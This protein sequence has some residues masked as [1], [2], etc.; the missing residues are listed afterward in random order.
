MK[1][2]DWVPVPSTLNAMEIILLPDTGYR[3]ELLAL[4]HEMTQDRPLLPW[5]T[6]LLQ[7]TGEALTSGTPTFTIPRSVVDR[8]VA[9]PTL[10]SAEVVEDV[11][12]FL[13]EREKLFDE[14]HEYARR[15]LRK[16]F[17]RRGALKGWK[18]PRDF[19]EGFWMTSENLEPLVVQAWEHLKLQRQIGLD[20]LL[21][22]QV[23]RLFFEMQGIAAYDRVISGQQPK[24]AHYTDIL[25]LMY[26]GMWRRRMLATEDQALSRAAKDVLYGRY[27]RT[28]VCGIREL[29]A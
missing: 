8:V 1:A 2:T 21:K 3:D 29:L 28:R 19:L 4:L 15:R 6:D 23:W 9:E 22:N 25:Q 5:P 16:E 12:A 10:I 14:F 24:R 13:L 11:K 7:L 27:A 18:T 20:R 17:E 26:L